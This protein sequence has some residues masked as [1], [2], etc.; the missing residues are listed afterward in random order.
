MKAGGARNLW[1]DQPLAPPAEDVKLGWKSRLT[2]LCDLSWVSRIEKKDLNIF[3]H[4]RLREEKEDLKNR[5]PISLY[6]ST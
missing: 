2:S 3:Q 5:D 1:S 6:V 4:R